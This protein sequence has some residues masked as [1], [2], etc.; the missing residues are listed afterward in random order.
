M[1]SAGSAKIILSL[2]DS[3]MCQSY[4]GGTFH[5]PSRICSTN[6]S[7]QRQISFQPGD[8]ENFQYL[9][10]NPK[11]PGKIF[12]ISVDLDLCC[13]GRNYNHVISSHQYLPNLNAGWKHLQ[14]F[15]LWIFSPAWLRADVRS[16]RGGAGSGSLIYAGHCGEHNYFKQTWGLCPQVPLLWPLINVFPNS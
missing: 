6:I 13:G 2:L 4:Q 14:Y 11:P 5:T 10:P 3:W 12:V 7:G 9:L 15:C 16:S 8:S 1:P